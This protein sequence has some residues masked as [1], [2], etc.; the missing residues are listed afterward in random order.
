[1]ANGKHNGV[2][3]AVYRFKAA[4]ALPRQ[5]VYDYGCV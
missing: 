1:M 2:P 3:F 4:F 5:L